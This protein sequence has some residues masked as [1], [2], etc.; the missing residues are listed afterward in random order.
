MLFVVNS[1]L[2]IG[3][4]VPG[5]TFYML[6]VRALVEIAL[7]VNALQEERM[8]GVTLCLLF[9]CSFVDRMSYDIPLL[10]LC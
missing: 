7:L 10:L 8:G 4:F 1:V 3:H 2:L 6:N 5:F 9:L